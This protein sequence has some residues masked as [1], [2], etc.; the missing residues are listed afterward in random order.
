MHALLRQRISEKSLSQIAFYALA[1]IPLCLIFSRLAADVCVTFIGLLLLTRSV[2]SG[3]WAWVKAPPVAILLALWLYTL[4]VVSPLAIDP[5]LSFGRGLTWVRYI[6]FFA[7]VAYW[8]TLEN[9]PWDKLAK[10]LAVLLCLVCIDA[11]IQYISGVSLTGYEKPGTRLDAAFGRMVVGIYL[12]K[13][14]FL[15]VGLGLYHAWRNKRSYA[16]VFYTAAL[17]AALAMIALSNE[18]TALLCYV[19]GLSVAGSLLLIFFKPVRKAV[20][21]LAIAHVLLLLTIYYTQSMFQGR[22]NESKQ[23]L[24]SFQASPYAQLWKSSIM[25]WQENPVV[26]VGLRNFRLVCPELMATGQITYCDLHSHNVYLEW[27]SETGIIGFGGFLLFIA[28]LLHLFWK[29]RNCIHTE[30][31]ILVAFALAALVPTLFPLAATQSFFS[32]WPAILAWFSI[33]CSAGMVRRAIYDR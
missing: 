8:L 6:L 4:F 30:R 19:I 17:T 10:W 15:V 18:R 27:L 23:M 26:G 31:M 13:T 14:T 29:A 12:A 5:A 25:I 32:N 9:L 2:I 16:K 21:V 28:S 24:H 33:A 7:A 11:L 20:V 22:V 1:A 3:D